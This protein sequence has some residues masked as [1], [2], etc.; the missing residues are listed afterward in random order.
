M[1]YQ[2]LQ[3]I[4]VTTLFVVAVV[5]L[6]FERDLHA[7]LQWLVFAL[8]SVSTIYG[9]TQH[10]P[11]I[12]ITSPNGILSQKNHILYPAIDL[13]LAITCY[14][15]MI[16]HNQQTTYCYARALF[17]WVLVSCIVLGGLGALYLGDLW[18]SD[19]LASVLLASALSISYCLCYRKTHPY[20]SPHSLFFSVTGFLMLC[21]A[22]ALSCY[23]YLKQNLQNHQIYFPQHIVSH[24]FWW[25]QE[26]P[27]L[28]LY[29]RN[30]IGKISG[31]FNIQYVGNIKTLVTSLT[32][33]GWK[34]QK[35]SLLNSVLKRMNAKE[36]PVRSLNECF[37]L[38]RPAVM[39]MTFHLA[40][41]HVLFR[42]Q[43]W[44]SNFYLYSFRSPIW[45]GHIQQ[46]K[47]KHR[48]RAVILSQ[49]QAINIM[50]EQLSE[51]VLKTISLPSS[52]HLS[53]PP[54]QERKLLLIQAP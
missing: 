36:M 17:S 19:L 15:C 52:N 47:L 39:T 48:H 25:N 40:G 13:T 31:T 28:P 16:F 22:T 46:L 45:I 23:L 5:F 30:R 34:I 53:L 27:L 6:I 11:V 3:P 10:L 7:V 12:A 18:I 50:D 9:L 14:L 33:K 1:T 41:S 49:D 21:T 24:S 20:F 26:K 51:F 32:Q 44:Q 8:L 35:S 29:S 2:S 43:L 38:N 54:S 37:Y 4:P 42:L